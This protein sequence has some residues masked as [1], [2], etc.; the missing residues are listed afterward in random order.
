MVA[1][2]AP[3]MGNPQKLADWI[4]KPTKN[5]SDYPAM[6]PQSYLPPEIRLEVARYVLE[7]VEP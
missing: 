7:R 5:R 4:A 2:R 1:A 3:Y 6:P